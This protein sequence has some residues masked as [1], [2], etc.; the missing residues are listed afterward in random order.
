MTDWYKL[1]PLV[2]AKAVVDVDVEAEEVEVGDVV[3]APAVAAC[4]ASG[5]FRMSLRP[6]E[7]EGD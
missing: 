4:G 1:F 7:S 6:G 2:P 3:E 5:A